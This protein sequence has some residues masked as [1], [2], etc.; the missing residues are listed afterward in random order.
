MQ[1]RRLPSPE[2]PR[3][4]RRHPLTDVLVGL[5]L[6]GILFVVVRTGASINV[7]FDE[8][9]APGR[10]STDPVHLP[11]YAARSLLRMFIALVLSVIFTF[12]YA[13]WAARSKRAEKVLIPL[14]D[15]LQS[16]PVL[17]FLSVTVTGF[18]AL[19]PGSAIGPELASIFAVFTAM[20]WNMT[21]AFYHS[22]ITQPEE[23]DEA[24]R[25]MGLTR[26][27]RFWKLD[28][29]GGMSPLIWN[30]MMSFAGAWFFLAASET[31]SVLNRTYALPGMGS[32]V[33]TALQDADTRSIWL[34]IVVM[35]LMIVGVNFLFWQP[36]LAWAER[37]RFEESA[38][39]E[40][41]RST[42]LDLLRRSAIPQLS[43][44]VLAP[45][46]E[47]LDRITRPLGRTGSVRTTS[48]RRERIIDWVFWG[49]LGLGVAVLMVFAAR[50][51]ADTVGFA[52]L[53]RALG[54]GGITLARVMAVLVFSTIIWVPVGLWIGSNP[55]VLRVAQ[56]VVQVLASFPA[57]FLYP[58][59]AA[60]FL[61]TG[62][63]LDIGGIV[64]MA[65]GSQW[66]ILFN[67]IEATTE[68]PS[69][70]NDLAGNLG[71]PLWQRWRRISLPAVF[72]AYI[73]GAI[74]AAGGAWNASIVAEVANFGDVQLVATGLG[75]YI[76]EATAVG[77]FPRIF[78]GVAI[79]S[80][81]VVG[82][83]RILWNP[84]YNLASKRYGM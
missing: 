72:P 17:G 83:N 21:F 84:L 51:V 1:G 79:M 81:Y 34:A 2:S 19:F 54:L 9:N 29:P 57:N 56:P 37:F 23:L 43:T 6:L 5:G 18:I 65:L 75:S 10:V 22:L 11:Y 63:S 76:T 68:I 60:L 61:A 48:P 35:A 3:L 8:A 69:D 33:A 38:T 40:G 74:T 36:C 70:W 4:H 42:I 67:I 27:Q 80:L 15:I 32:F 47:A 53:W 82:V 28:V 77:D 49:V 20:A 45:V 31:I 14:L 46:G 12:V 52:E 71:M 62:L 41:T 55:R 73:T 44:R 78:I 59:M 24:A 64:L 25:M 7:P 13:T 26:W 50:Y 30:G 16:V 39:G 58:L 66:Y